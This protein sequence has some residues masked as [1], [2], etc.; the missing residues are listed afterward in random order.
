[1]HKEKKPRF[2]LLFDRT[3]P[4]AFT[5]VFILKDRSLLV[6]H[7]C[8]EERAQFDQFLSPF[9]G[10]FHRVPDDPEPPSRAFKKL[11]EAQMYFGKSI[12]QNEH[13][14]AIVGSPGGWTHIAK[15]RVAH[16]TSVDRSTL[17]KS[18]M[19]HERVSF[20]MGDA[21]KYQTNKKVDWALSDVIA[22]PQRVIKL[23]ENWPQKRACRY[24]IFTVK[25]QGKPDYSTLER[26]KRKAAQVCEVFYLTQ[27]NSN[28]NEATIMGKSLM[29]GEPHE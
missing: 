20:H 22:H 28:K 19:D 13:V 18:L 9:V 7:L 8:E 1:M 15:M 24:F 23:M 26:L 29:T 11:I 10:G 5:Q 12:Q 3:R 4:G 17:E 14:I 21:F 25:F 6:S 2:N 16:V 27:L